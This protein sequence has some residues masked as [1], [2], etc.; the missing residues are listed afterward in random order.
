M[1]HAI[2]KKKQSSTPAKEQVQYAT[3]E[4]FADYAEELI[5]CGD[6]KN[7]KELLADAKKQWTEYVEFEEGKLTDEIVAAAAPQLEHFFKKEGG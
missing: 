3:V 7:L 1:G 2:I 5:G 6:Y 4:R